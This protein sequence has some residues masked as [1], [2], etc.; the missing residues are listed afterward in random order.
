MQQYRADE[1]PASRECG[2]ILPQ[3]IN[4]NSDCA[5]EKAQQALPKWIEIVR[6]HGKTEWFNIKMTPNR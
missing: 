6:F 3:G 2:W 4:A 5:G 1:A